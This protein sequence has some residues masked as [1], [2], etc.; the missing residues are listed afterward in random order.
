MNPGIAPIGL[1]LNP[2]S[3]DGL[4]PD[5][6]G[7]VRFNCLTADG[8]PAVLT[9]TPQQAVMV[10]ELLPDYVDEDRSVS[11]VTMALVC[12]C[13]IDQIDGQGHLRT[14]SAVRA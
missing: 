13:T 8:R 9:L 14:C 5:S 12:G 10:G 1:V 6:L 11:G 2:E 3:G 4:E 7:T